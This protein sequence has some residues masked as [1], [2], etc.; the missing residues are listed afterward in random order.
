MAG[1]VKVLLKMH[2]KYTAFHRFLLIT[3]FSIESSQF[4]SV[5]ITFN[6]LKTNSTKFAHCRLKIRKVIEFFYFQSLMQHL[7]CRACCKTFVGKFPRV[8]LY[9]ESNG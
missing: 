2:K 5:W 7:L 4:S 3:I 8:I 1:Y 9:A 6:H